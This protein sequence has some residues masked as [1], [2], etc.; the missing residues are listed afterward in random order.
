MT[1]WSQAL[2]GLGVLCV[3]NATELSIRKMRVAGLNETKHTVKSLQSAM[4]NKT[5]VAWR[6]KWW[7]VVAQYHPQPSYVSFIV[8]RVGMAGQPELDIIDVDV[9]VGK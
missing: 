5:K 2:H 8:S 4:K 1:V 6:G 9:E 3:G 7:K